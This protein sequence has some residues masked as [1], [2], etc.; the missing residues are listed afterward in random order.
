[1]VKTLHRISFHARLFEESRSSIKIYLQHAPCWMTLQMNQFYIGCSQYKCHR[2]HERT[3]HMVTRAQSN[4]TARWHQVTLTSHIDMILHWPVSHYSVL[5]NIARSQK[6]VSSPFL[7][8]PLI[9][10]ERV[11]ECMFC[12]KIPCERF[13]CHRSYN[14]K[15]SRNKAWQEKHFTWIW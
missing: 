6:A 12:G 2:D 4:A 3:F 13:A 10:L 15:K 9:N 14:Y 1:M 11:A 5:A 7:S 8:F